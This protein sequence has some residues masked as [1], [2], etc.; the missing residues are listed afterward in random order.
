M[1]RI[2]LRFRTTT[3]LTSDEACLRQTITS[4][5][6]DLAEAN[7]R[8]QPPKPSE[9][10]VKHGFNPI[11]SIWGVS[12][13]FRVRREVRR[14]AKTIQKLTRARGAASTE[15]RGVLVAI[16]ARRVRSERR[17]VVAGKI[18]RTAIFFIAAPILGLM[19]L[20][21]VL[22]TFLPANEH[23]SDLSS[24]SGLSSSSDIGLSGNGVSTANRP[25]C[26][27]GIPCR[28]TCISAQDICH[29]DQEKHTTSDFE[30]V[31][32]YSR[33]DGTYVQPYDRARPHGH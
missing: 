12:N 33:H 3:A 22:I 5:D 14:L 26:M 23:G 7:R 4:L 13:R 21:A 28:N 25:R 17:K 10:R 31:S 32:G 24:N 11:T 1:P 16:E 2:P 8:A 9:P 30:H 15:H 20:S 18:A 19:I 6:A 29:A 27:V